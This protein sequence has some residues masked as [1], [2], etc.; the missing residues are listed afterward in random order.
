MSMYDQFKNLSRE[1]EQRCFQ[2]VKRGDADARVRLIK[3]NLRLVVQI[4]GKL[5]E[6]GIAEKDDLTQS[7]IEGLMEAIEKFDPDRGFKFSSFASVLI[8]RSMQKSFGDWIT[9]KVPPHKV[10]LLN[11]IKKAQHTLHTRDGIESPSISQV[12]KES[13]LE[14]SDVEELIYFTFLGKSAISLDDNSSTSVEKE[15]EF[16]KHEIVPSE[17][18][19]PTEA[20]DL[21]LL[22]ELFLTALAKPEF[23]GFKGGNAFHIYFY[24]SEDPYESRQFFR[25]YS[26]KTVEAVASAL[27]DSIPTPYTRRRCWIAFLQENPPATETNICG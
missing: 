9:F 11:A 19:S 24:G 4:A 15:E 27:R 13:E 12:A 20:I 18:P 25:S 5:A 14:E 2:L 3:G 21:N 22:K 16:T 23:T 17:D 6:L 7:G 1:E 10:T 26:D 8:K